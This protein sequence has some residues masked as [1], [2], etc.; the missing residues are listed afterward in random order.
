MSGRFF[1]VI[2][3]AILSIG[4]VGQANAGLITG[5]IVGGI[6]EDFTGLKWKYVTKYDLL[7]A[8]P[9]NYGSPDE[10]LNGLQAAQLEVA[11][12]GL[13]IP[14]K[15]L[16]LA[17][18][19]N[20]KSAVIGGAVVNHKAFYEI[21]GNGVDTL[22]EDISNPGG[23]DG[24]YSEIDDVSAYVR[25]QANTSY[26]NYIFQRTVDVPEP[27]TLAV[28]ALALFGLGARRFKKS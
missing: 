8:P 23:L 6:Y 19:D 20:T 10:A 9:F 22:A 26:I 12:L 5:L 11:A 3:A 15:D 4:L 1:K 17:A 14:L 16:A 28:I 25:D 18:Y 2:C 27:S 24:L 7:Q 13:N 21:V